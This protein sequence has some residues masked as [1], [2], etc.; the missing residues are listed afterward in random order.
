MTLDTSSAARGSQRL[1]VVA[2]TVIQVRGDT[3]EKRAALDHPIEPTDDL[4]LGVIVDAGEVP[5]HV[6]LVQQPQHG[7]VFVGEG[8]QK[9][10]EA[11]PAVVEAQQ[12]AMHVPIQEQVFQAGDELRHAAVDDALVAGT[13]HSRLA[14]GRVALDADVQVTSVETLHVDHLL[15]EDQGLVATLDDGADLRIDPRIPVK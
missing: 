6:R 13:L 7:V 8:V 11:H 9:G 15:L 4:G 14:H 5:V 10:G 2:E 3:L 12:D 1:I